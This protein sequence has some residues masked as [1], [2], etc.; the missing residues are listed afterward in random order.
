[1]KKVVGIRFK[2]AG[3]VYDFDSGA[4]V[5]NRGDHVVVETEQGLGLGM[6]RQALEEGV[7]SR[8]PGGLSSKRKEFGNGKKSPRLLLKLHSGTGS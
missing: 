1:M 3:K 2:P 4:F 8:E 6:V 5:L 7:P